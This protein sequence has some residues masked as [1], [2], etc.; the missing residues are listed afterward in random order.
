MEMVEKYKRERYC[1]ENIVI[2]FAGGVDFATADALVESYFGGLAKGN[3][4]KREIQVERKARTLTKKKAIEQTHLAIS[5]PS[6]YRGHELGDALQTLNTILGGG[7]SSRLFQEIREKQGLAY[8]V[9][10]YL[11]TY[12]SVGSLIVYAGVNPT[13]T[14]QAYGAI[15][16]LVKELKKNGVSEEEFLRGREQMKS[17]MLFSQES[18]SSQ[19]LVYGK[20]ALYYDTVYDFENRFK[21][22]NEMKKQAVVDALE[23]TLNDSE[24]CVAVVGNI[25]KKFSL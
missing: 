6:L 20:H 11:S 18:T 7:M 17:S 8:S 19:M 4:Q 16:E 12:E 21:R 9:Y 22:I 1:P 13:N 23:L 3:F 10:S 25:T 24:K 5:Y 15:E 14:K 2:T